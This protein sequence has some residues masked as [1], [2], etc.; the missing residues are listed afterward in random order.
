MEWAEF[1]THLMQPNGP[2]Q[3]F[4]EVDQDWSNL[5]SRLKH[6][7]D[8]QKDAEAIA[9]RSYEVFNRRYLTPAAVSCYLRRLFHGWAAVQGFE[10]RIFE[11]GSDK[12]R[13]SAFEALAVSFP[14]ARPGEYEKPAPE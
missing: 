12:L 2:E 5:P 7:L 14:Q 1:A 9:E 8:H 6:L 4:V 13:G 11:E 10:P 3:N